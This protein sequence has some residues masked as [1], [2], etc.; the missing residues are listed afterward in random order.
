MRTRATVS[1]LNESLSEVLVTNVNTFGS[2]G[3]TGFITPGTQ[4][5]GVLITNE[6]RDETI[7]DVPSPGQFTK[8]AKHTVVDFIRYNPDIFDIRYQANVGSDTVGDFIYRYTGEVPQR[9]YFEADK[10]GRVLPSNLITTFPKSVDDHVRTTLNAFFNENEVNNLL[11]IVES[12][13]LV[14]SLKQLKSDSKILGKQRFK[15]L[16][17]LSKVAANNHL[18][19]AFGVA[20]LLSDMKKMQKAIGNIS[21]D[22]EHNRRAQNGD[23]V[24]HRRF[25]G[26][27]SN[28]LV[29]MPVGFSSYSDPQDETYWHVGF[30]PLMF[31]TRIVTVRGKWDVKY[32]TDTFKDLDYLMRRFLSSG[33]ATFAWERIPFSF[34]VD[35]FVDLSS[36]LNGLDNLLTDS[37]TTIKDICIS[38]KYEVWLPAY[39]HQ[40]PHYPTTLDGVQIALSKL[41]YYNRYR[42][43]D[44]KLNY[45]RP[46][47][48]FKF[49]QAALSASLLRQII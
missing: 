14:E 20:P 45:I 42:Y 11:N 31:P 41:R 36:I 25:I 15:S 37:Q 27:F 48:R 33:P 26:S 18:A 32:N 28:E 22:L 13:Q 6:R 8:Y 9:G 38:E 49:K 29:D 16:K 24:L 4:A 34:V 44:Y 39:I 12:P 3:W 35:W 2:S 30:N 10:L 7:T 43:A 21:R 17:K 1:N 19:W 23:K 40:R 47:G 46:S 5:F